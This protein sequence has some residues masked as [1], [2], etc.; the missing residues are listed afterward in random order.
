MPLVDASDPAVYHLN[1]VSEANR[2]WYNHTLNTSI[3]VG[4]PQLL[5]GYI[6]FARLFTARNHAKGLVVGLP[7]K[8]GDSIILSGAGFGWLEEEMRK[9]L[10]ASTF[11]SYDNGGWVNSVKATDET[12][13]V[14]ALL[15]TAGIV[16][17][18]KRSDWHS[19]MVTG[20]RAVV[21]VADEDGGTNPS[22]NRIK[23]RLG[24]QGNRNADWFI[25]EQVLAWL[26]DAECQS[27]SAS[28]HRMA[29]N[30]VHL[31]S[32]FLASK[33]SEQ[34]QNPWNWKHQDSLDPT[35]ALLESQPWYTTTSWKALLPEDVIVAPSFKYRAV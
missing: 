7:I 2:L 28:A 35:T 17:P 4:E 18:G 1:H 32:V 26:D 23:G 15:D 24:L 16:D 9:L 10:P 20:P 12:V 5:V 31:T 11:V 29:D 34:E 19:R 13:E 3:P 30:V 27:L 21:T 8:D 25:S 22:R 6:R 33:A 14:D